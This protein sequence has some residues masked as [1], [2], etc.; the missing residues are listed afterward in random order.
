MKNLKLK[1]ITICFIY[2]SFLIV[3]GLAIFYQTQQIDKQSTEISKR[4]GKFES[5]LSEKTRAAQA[6][7][8]ELGYGGM[9]HH[10]KNMVLRRDLS[11]ITDI[12]AHISRSRSTLDRYASVSLNQQEKLA[13]KAL[14]TTLTAYEKATLEVKSA[15]ENNHS[16]ENID[17]QV[18]IND[19]PALQALDNLEIE[20]SSNRHHNNKITKARLLNNL[21]RILGF[22]GMIHQFKNYIL[23]KEHALH[24]IVLTKTAQA[25]SIVEKYYLL[26]HTK[27]EADALHRI[28]FVIKK[29]EEA[30]HLV[31]DLIGQGGVSAQNI[32]KHVRID[33]SPAFDGLNSLVLQIS[34][35]HNK[36]AISINKYL[37]KLREMAATSIWFFSIAIITLIVLFYWLFKIQII[38]PIS[39]VTKLLD[40]LANGYTN[41]D[42]NI[43]V[44]SYSIEIEQLLSASHF[45]K[46]QSQTLSQERSLL[47]SIL[48]SLPDA[49][50]WKNT[51][52][53]YEGCNQQFLTLFQV[54]ENN[55]IGKTDLDI[56]GKKSA[57]SFAKEDAQALSQSK[58]I[59]IEKT[60]Q[61]AD[62][63]TVFL[64][65]VITSYK[66]ESSHEIIGLIG[67]SHDI[68]AHK[69]LH[70][71]LT[72]AKDNADTANKIKSDFLANMSHEI[73]TPMN[74]IIGL[75][76]L[77]LRT[78]LTPQQQDYLFKVLD[79]SNSLLGLLNDILDFS[80]I[81]AGKLDIEYTEFQLE[82]VLNNV[83]QIVGVKVAEKN[84][85]FI[86]DYANNL[87]NYLI[88]DPLRLGQIL[89]N[90]I[91][92]A[93]KFTETGQVILK[94]TSLK[95]DSEQIIL[96]FSVEDTGIGITEE[97]LT[98]LFKS[99][100]QADNSTSRQ[101]GGTG[102]GLAI[103]KNLVELMSGEISAESTPNKGSRFVFNIPFK[104][105]TE[106]HVDKTLPNKILGMHALIV[107]DNIPSQLVL[108]QQL[109]DFGFKV[110]VV[111][112]GSEAITEVTTQKTPPY[113]LIIMDWNMPKKNGIDSAK[114]IRQL[115][116]PS[117][118]KI[119]MVSGHKDHQL[120][121]QAEEIGVEAF[122]LKPINHSIMLNTIL[123]VFEETPKKSM[124]HFHKADY[125]EPLLKNKSIFLVED[126]LINQQIARELLEQAGLTVTIAN[127]GQECID[128]LERFT[129]DCIL[130]D[131]QMP[132]LDGIE[133]S[134]RI[135]EMPKYDDLPIIAM[136]ANAMKTDIEN[137][138]NVGMND[139][140]AKPINVKNLFDT[141]KKWLIKQDNSSS[142]S[143]NKLI[144]EK[145]LQN[146]EDS[147]T[148]I[149]S[150]DEGM[151]R[152]SQNHELYLKILGQFLDMNKNTVFD[153]KQ[154]LANP[155]KTRAFFIL[156][157]L[158]GA[159]GSIGANQV[160]K[161]SGL[162]EQTLKS[163]S[164]D[165]Y[166]LFAT[167]EDQLTNLKTTIHKY[168]ESHQKPNTESPI[169]INDMDSNIVI[170]QLSLIQKSLANSDANV[171]EQMKNL[172]KSFENTV[173]ES[174]FKDAIEQAES[175][176]FDEANSIISDILLSL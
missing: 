12:E 31:S 54:S 171:I 148:E 30:T 68:T 93:I 28:S 149:L 41:L 26:P 117:Q 85:D 139:H 118:P 105:G 176:D 29:Y 122:L 36:D 3:V 50:Y 17:T 52:G 42:I 152:V 94:I 144:E 53:I 1:L 145:P 14:H 90:L 6:L 142:V 169:L 136:T 48:N 78:S 165:F 119:I 96:S 25:K 16:P 63:K 100:S 47:Q 33:D 91:T 67:V 155:D 131:L 157:T 134:R 150:I 92:N 147:S 121:A 10:F 62:S 56:F 133:T 9:I 7:N 65:T 106:K 129:Y 162:L 166:I 70:Q 74:A 82:K 45:F 59:H 88:G 61:V 173:L 175:F 141:L 98:K 39:H 116:L 18:K 34:I 167:L 95:N 35:E 140:I 60:A 154:A 66:N 156:H 51:A 40:Q 79:S 146:L 114:E 132:I 104:P 76:E 81:E 164:N 43:D 23:R 89:I 107:D 126:N 64:D 2:I 158:K 137:C 55:I 75:S 46:E 143:V 22:G 102:L 20:D 130:M 38:T 110:N 4:W 135:R 13:L 84:I 57:I 115:P 168:K 99:F 27:A 24:T 160:F 172:S 138:L 153:L 86:Y 87:P 161:T 113:S 44:K 80:K 5:D 127:N 159:A 73:R 15:I 101:Y 124:E 103:C 58:P 125:K 151:E 128:N 163:K 71:E 109:K 123:D 112:S 108:A 170:S 77:T 97:Q 11:K 72:I 21:R 49:V 19:I 32:D 69:M 8:N 174:L 111:C 120:V 83:S 37:N